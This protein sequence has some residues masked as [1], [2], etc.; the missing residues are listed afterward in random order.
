MGK[1]RKGAVKK[2]VAGTTGGDDAKTAG[3]KKSIGKVK[4][5]TEANAA[6]TKAP[7]SL[8]GPLRAKHA[9][10]AAA[11]RTAK[12]KAMQ[13]ATLQGTPKQKVDGKVQMQQIEQ[14]RDHAE[15]VAESAGATNDATRRRA[16]RAGKHS[17]QVL[18]AFNAPAAFSLPVR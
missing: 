11:A 8:S 17:R 10:I 14:A 18:A 4:K 6:V 2:K 9:A 16:G 13:R 3:V 7:A 12:D 5:V 1:N 15:K